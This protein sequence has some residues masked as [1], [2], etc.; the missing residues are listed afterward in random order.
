MSAI[1]GVVELIGGP[2]DGAFI[3]F[4]P[5]LERIR[6]AFGT[7]L[8]SEPPVALYD[9]VVRAGSMRAEFCGLESPQPE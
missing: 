1:T 3:S 8:C 2:V 4:T 5:G 9:L 6:V 7:C